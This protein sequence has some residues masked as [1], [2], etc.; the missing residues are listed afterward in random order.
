MSF[1][2]FLLINLRNRFAFF[3]NIVLPVVFMILFGAVFGKQQAD[4]SVAYYS[5]KEIIIDSTNW[6][7]LRS[8]PTLDEI[9]KSK[10]DAVIIAKDNS[11]DVY[12]KSNLLQIEY[13]LQVFKLKYVASNQNIPV[14]LKI[15]NVSIGK[16][17]SELE[18][19]MIGVIAISLLSV[20]MNAGV[21]MYSDYFRYGLFK[22]LS[23]TPINPFSLLLSYIGAN[24][25]TG[26]ISSFV[27]LIL[28]KIIFG[29]NL[30]IHLSKVPLYL[31]VVS[32]S[33]L[34][35][36]ALG[37]VLSLVFKKSAQSISQLLYTV[38]IF[39]S[40]V[41]FPLEF[42]PKSLRYISYLTTPRYVHML[43]QWIYDIPVMNS[44]LF[45][46]LNAVFIILGIVIGSF[47]TTRF[48]QVRN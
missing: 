35:N 26:V 33:V 11:I 2:S 14:N 9:K 18:Y 5:D 27:I 23:H 46:V 45:Y 32:S 12:Q 47:A 1:Y 31:L 7:P 24:S 39:F 40:G 28:S 8:I 25:L 17:L 43:F 42:L 19:I 38:F 3:M 13:E 6:I 16:E 29:T 41:Y 22:R 44:V 30:L 10:Y 34:I 21:N 36:S 37:V 20:G 4:A 15:E 48:L